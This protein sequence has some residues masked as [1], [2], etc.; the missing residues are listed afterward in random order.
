V[1][2]YLLKQYVQPPISAHVLLIFLYGCIAQISVI[3]YEM[4]VLYSELG[5]GSMICSPLFQ[6]NVYAI[7]FNNNSD[8]HTLI[9]DYQ[10]IMCANSTLLKANSRRQD[11]KKEYGRCST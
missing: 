8:A 9:S 2:I 1:A 4:Y 3:G 6:A 11:K 10:T 7:L 5:P